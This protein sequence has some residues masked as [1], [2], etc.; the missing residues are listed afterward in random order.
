MTRSVL[1]WALVAIAGVVLAAIQ[2]DGGL[3]VQRPEA[4]MPM[5]LGGTVIAI[6]GLLKLVAVATDP[7]IRRRR[8]DGSEE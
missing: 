6:A 4:R 8:E 7:K 1:P 3:I 2:L 5:F